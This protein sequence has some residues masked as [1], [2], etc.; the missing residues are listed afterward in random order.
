MSQIQHIVMEGDFTDFTLTEVLEVASLS[1]QLIQIVL[2]TSTHI[3]S[4]IMMKSGQILEV[5]TQSD[6]KGLQAFSLLLKEKFA[7]F[8][9]IR[10][11]RTRSLVQPLGSL[12]D[13][14]KPQK[15]EKKPTYVKPEDPEKSPPPVLSD[16]LFGSTP[17]P[18]SYTHLTLPTICSV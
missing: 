17:E 14:L 4:K 18:V 13:L 8:Q 12:V 7:F 16:S 3:Q 6:Q 9:I 11:K 1:R 5:N 10:I 2:S 15:I